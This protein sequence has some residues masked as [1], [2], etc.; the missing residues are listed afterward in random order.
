M[1]QPSSTD[2]APNT[3]KITDD[4]SNSWGSL[5][6]PGEAAPKGEGT[7][8]L[9]PVPVAHVVLCGPVPRVHPLP[10]EL[11]RSVGPKWR[12][13]YSTATKLRVI[14]ATRLRC[15]DGGP[16][17]NRGAATGLGQGRIC[18]RL[19]PGSETAPSLTFKRLASSAPGRLPQ[20]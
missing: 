19:T 1:S 17:G 14:D 11:E 13:S 6:R 12:H 9:V 7:P 20:K 4:R 15:N 16:V 18:P 8:A 3:D 2:K 5:R 10:F